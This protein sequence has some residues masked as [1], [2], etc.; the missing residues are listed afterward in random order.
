MDEVVATAAGAVAEALYE[1]GTG[2]PSVVSD[3]RGAMDSGLA[4]LLAAGRIARVTGSCI[5]ADK[6]F[7][8]STWPVSRRSR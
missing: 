4:V 3:N 8:R 1:Q 5:G 2:S 7:A 6:E